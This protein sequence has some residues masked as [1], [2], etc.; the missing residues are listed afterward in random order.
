MLL[1]CVVEH[2]E[3]VAPAKQLYFTFE[4]VLE[5]FRSSFHPSTSTTKAEP[6]V[7]TLG[8][9][10]NA[11]IKYRTDVFREKERA[12]GISEDVSLVDELLR[13]P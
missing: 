10:F 3:H 11:L 4:P 6:K 13:T 2:R 5:K 7:R 8:D 12:S 1:Q 9:K